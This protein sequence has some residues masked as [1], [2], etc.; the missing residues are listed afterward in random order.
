MAPQRSRGRGK[1]LHR[2]R[3][4]NAG[5]VVEPVRV[6]ATDPDGAVRFATPAGETPEPPGDHGLDVLVRPP[7]RLFGRPRQYAFQVTVTPRHPVPPVR[8]DGSRESLALLP[9]WFAVLSV[10]L[11]LL[12]CLAGGA[13]TLVPRALDA[14]NGGNANQRQGQ[15][16]QTQGQQQQQNQNNQNQNT[17]KAHA[18]DQLDIDEGDQADLD[19]ITVTGR[20][21]DIAF[22]ADDGKKRFVVPRNGAR[23]AA[24]GAVDNAAARCA[25]ASFG[26]DPV[27]ADG[28]DKGDVLCVSTSAGRLAV[29]SV[30]DAIGDSPGTLRLAVTTFDR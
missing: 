5:N 20:G 25:A 14:L 4:R 13:A 22:Q 16:Q 6:E 3:V 27:P 28:F 15:G 17:P 8:L 7:F 23:V 11:V 18:Q 2:V 24:L 29:A 9:R 10:V 19:E 1:T 26:T 21:A 30:R 12:G